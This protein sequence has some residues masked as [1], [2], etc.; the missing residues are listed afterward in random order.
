MAQHLLGFSIKLRVDRR[1]WRSPFQTKEKGLPRG[2]AALNSLC[3]W[4]FNRSVPVITWHTRKRLANAELA[5][6]L[7]CFY[8]GGLLQALDRLLRHFRF[9]LLIGPSGA[10]PSYMQVA[11]HCL[12]AICHSLNPVKSVS[13]LRLPGC[14]A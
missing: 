13:P 5:E 8:L 6:R 10:L 3:Y 11:S 7:A 1:A 14:Y 4:T 9:P 2:E 12:R